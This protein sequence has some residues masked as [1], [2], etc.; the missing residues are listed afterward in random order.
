MLMSLSGSSPSRWSS[1]AI[2]TLAI[3]SRPLGWHAP[4]YA[5]RQRAARE[6]LDRLSDE[7]GKIATDS[8]RVVRVGLEPEP[9]CAIETPADAADRLAGVNADHIGV[10]L[11]TC[12]LATGFE[13]PAQAVA[14]LADAGLAV[15]KAQVS[16]ALHVDTPS[17]PATAA[18]LES[19]AEDR[20]LHQVRQRMAGRVLGRDDLPDAMA[21]ARRPLRGRSPWRVHF[22]VPVHTEPEPP[23]R[24]TSDE[25]A[26]ALGVLAGADTPVTHHLEVETYT[27]SVLPPGQ[28]P[29]DDGELIAGLG[30][31]L[32]WTR[33]RLT[34]LGLEAK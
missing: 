28:R 30:A 25:L 20:F 18:A 34:A 31:E 4:W 6:H 14:T 16:A 8:G 10:C 23:L 13:D 27:W 5:D 19:F 9:G 22:H 12:H 32:A 29:A 3:S 2:T 24:S 7:L 26:G 21:G 17:D 33:D 11:D 1:W 15:I